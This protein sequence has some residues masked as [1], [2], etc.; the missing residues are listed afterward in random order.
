MIMTD[1]KYS[2]IGLRAGIA[3]EPE[4]HGRCLPQAASFKNFS[5]AILRI[6]CTYLEARP[7]GVLVSE[8]DRVRYLHLFDCPI[9]LSEPDKQ[10]PPK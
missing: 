5:I 8:R 1:L 2:W 9:S 3:A 10:Q 7:T 6:Q 4:S